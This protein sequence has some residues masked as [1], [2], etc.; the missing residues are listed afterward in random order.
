MMECWHYNKK[1]CVK[2]KCW[3]QNENRGE[4][5]ANVIGVILQE[6][7]ILTFEIEKE[8]GTRNKHPH[9]SGHCIDHVA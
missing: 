2:K 1:G 6:D 8:V 9:R 7:L 3:L 4:P 5:E